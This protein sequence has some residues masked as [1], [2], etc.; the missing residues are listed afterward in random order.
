ME[1]PNTFR[2]NQQIQGR[3][4]AIVLALAILGIVGFSAQRGQDFIATLAQGSDFAQGIVADVTGGVARQ[5][6]NQAAQVGTISVVAGIERLDFEREIVA[7]LRQHR[8]G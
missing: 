3:L 2:E 1:A 4:L 6:P 8:S 7:K 5:L